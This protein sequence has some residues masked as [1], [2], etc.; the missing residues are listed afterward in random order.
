MK[1]RRYWSAFS[2]AERM[3]LLGKCTFFR[4]LLP[5][6]DWIIICIMAKKECLRC[7]KIPP[8][9]PGLLSFALVSFLMVRKTIHNLA[10]VQKVRSCWS[11]LR[12]I[13]ARGSVTVCLGPWSSYGQK[14]LQKFNIIT[15][16]CPPKRCCCLQSDQSFCIIMFQWQHV[17]VHGSHCARSIRHLLNHFRWMSIKAIMCLVDHLQTPLWFSTTSTLNELSKQQP[18]P[19]VQSECGNSSSLSTH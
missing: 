19:P 9:S 15:L 14:N 2:T 11:D 3:Q 7:I 1:R 10:T 5:P 12:L 17:S 8:S 6:S 16:K 13:H 18:P 4:I